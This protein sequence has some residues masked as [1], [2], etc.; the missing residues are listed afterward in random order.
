MTGSAI[1]PKRRHPARTALIV[2]AVL[3]VLLVIAAFVLDGIAR[4]T[5]ERTIETQVR[6]SLSIPAS[7][8]VKATVGGGSVLIQLAQGS[9]DHV[10]IRSTGLAIGALTGDAH[11]VATGLPLDQ[12]QPIDGVRL[13][14]ATDQAGLQKL[15]ANISNGAVDTARIASGAVKVTSTLKVLGLSVPVGITAV[16]GAASGAL[17]LTPKSFEV[18]GNTVTA[19]ALTSTLGSVAEPLTKTQTICVASSLP[20]AFSLRSVKIVGST[21]AL[22]V[23]GSDVLLGGKTL[24]T[25]GTCP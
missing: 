21:I 19:S 20:K 10:D 18:G 4:T 5:A 11:V 22:S 6:S 12:S 16:P 17:T 9:L 1:A 13:S 23:A 15:L 8:R 14:F 7:T 24:T 2:L 3:V 25:V